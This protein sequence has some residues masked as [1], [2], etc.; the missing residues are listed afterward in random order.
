M[1]HDVRRRRGGGSNR[2]QYGTLQIRVGSE[3]RNPI[4]AG[5]PIK[6]HR[7]IPKD[8]L[9]KWVKVSYYRVGASKHVWKVDVVVDEPAAS[10]ESCGKGA[11][12]IDIGWRVQDEQLRSVYWRDTKGHS[13]SLMLSSELRRAF[14]QADE[15]RGVRDSN[16]DRMKAQFISGNLPRWVCASTVGKNEAMPSLAQARSYLNQRKSFRRW[17]RLATDSRWKGKCPQ[18]LT[19]WSKQDRHLYDWEANQ[20]R[21]AVNRRRDEVRVFAAEMTRKYDTIIVEANE[22]ETKLMDLHFAVKRADPEDQAEN[23]TAR[24]NRQVEAPGATRLEITNAARK[25]AATVALISTA[26]AVRQ[27][28]FCGQ[29]DKQSKKGAPSC[30]RCGKTWDSADGTCRTLLQRYLTRRDQGENIPRL[31]VSTESNYERRTRNRKEKQQR[32]QTR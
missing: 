15:I 6:M 20:R 32:T 8:A 7:Q 22:N 4:W 2:P 25:R 14:K 29:V 3:G 5:W 13:G 9:V 10:S 24:H 11:V 19:D 17:A 28:P 21:K 31:E 1:V 26:G 27:C 12:A 16:L 23:K 18:V 30:S